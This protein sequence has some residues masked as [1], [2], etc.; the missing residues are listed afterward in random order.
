VGLQLENPEYKYL[1]PSN[2]FIHFNLVGEYK[3]NLLMCRIKSA[4]YE[5]RIFFI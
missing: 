5:H 1:Y 4:N 2:H 3:D